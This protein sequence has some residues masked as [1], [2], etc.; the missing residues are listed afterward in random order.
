[1]FGWDYYTFQRQPAFFIRQIAE[2]QNIEQFAQ[3]MKEVEAEKRDKPS[4]T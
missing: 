3:R 4:P 1:M 2:F